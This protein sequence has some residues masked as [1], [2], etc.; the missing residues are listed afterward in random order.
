M[1]LSNRLLPDHSAARPPAA[2]RSTLRQREGTTLMPAAASRS[3]TSGWLRAEERRVTRWS[4]GVCKLTD[5]APGRA[6]TRASQA[7]RGEL[8]SGGKAQN[9]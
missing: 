2:A 6:G 5:G 7:G 3:S 4:R 9:P 1:G 8:S